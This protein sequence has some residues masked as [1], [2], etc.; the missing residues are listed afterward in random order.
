[1]HNYFES[2]VKFEKT[3][4]DGSILKTTAKHL[5]D[6]LSFTE[7]EKRIIEEMNPFVSGEFLVS[8]LKRYK[9][10]ELFWNENSDKWFRAKVNFITLDEEKGVEKKTATYMLVQAND[11][12]EAREN[13]ENGMKGTMSDYE[14][15]SIT[16]TAIIGV[17]NYQ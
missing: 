4:E 17:F 7:A 5:I 3:M 15:V 2:T 8:H 12:K 1:M 13:L 16:E 14:T 6:A 9:V 10:S 11:I